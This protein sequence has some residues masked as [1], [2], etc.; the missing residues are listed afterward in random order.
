MLNLKVTTLVIFLVASAAVGAAGSTAITR[1]TSS[2]TAVSDCKQLYP[3]ETR[4]KGVI[5]NSA[6]GKEY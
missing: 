6:T 4:K 3:S 2:V 5:V 1:M